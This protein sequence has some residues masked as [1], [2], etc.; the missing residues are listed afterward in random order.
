MIDEDKLKDE[1][2]DM[3]DEIYSEGY[4]ILLEKGDPIQFE[5]GFRELVNELIAAEDYEI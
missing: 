5:V 3:L 4:G 1:Y 2:I